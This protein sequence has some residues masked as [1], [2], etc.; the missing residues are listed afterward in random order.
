MKVILCAGGTGGGIYPAIAMAQ[1]LRRTAPDSELLWL[2]GRGGMEEEL[3]PRAGIPFAAIPA[4]GIH[5]VGWRQAPANLFRLA[6]GTF[7]AWRRMGEFGGQ[8]LF[9]TGGYLAAPAVL[10]ARA[11]RIP[12]VVYV[13]DIE[14]ALAAKFAARFARRIAVTTQQ[15]TGFY[16]KGAPVTVTGYPLREEVFNATREAGRRFFGIPA[17]EPVLL[18]FGGSRGA[19]SI[20]RA[21]LGSLESLLEV[22]HVIHI[23][24]TLDWPEVDKVQ[25]HLPAHRKAR[26]HAH[27]YLHEEMGPAM[28]AA[29]LV[30][31]R[32]GASVLGEYPHF[33]L[34]SILVPYPHAWRYQ[35]TNAEFLESQGAAVILADDTLPRTLAPEAIR[36]MNSG[37]TRKE[38]RDVLEKINSKNS[39]LKLAGEVVAAAK[40]G[41][42]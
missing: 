9:V 21:L 29:D 15:S 7:T 24:G 39:S 3:V 40:E 10:A 41:P 28:A 22:M 42:K 20:N 19:R 31:S 35:Q 11:R 2:G 13:P 6:A 30:V 34:P 26:Y 23:T 37:A 36:I 27:P 18:V 12:V 17:E 14:P 16:P 8:V 4:A 38:M 1:A 25:Q 33:R 32:A 5:G